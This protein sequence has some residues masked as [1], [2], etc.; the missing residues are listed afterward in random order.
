MLGDSQQH[1]KTGYA[2]FWSLCL[3]FLVWPLAWMVA[4][5]WIFLQPFEAIET[6]GPPVAQVNSFLE[7]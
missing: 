3:L 5:F 1:R 4:P 6:L 2:V 7:R